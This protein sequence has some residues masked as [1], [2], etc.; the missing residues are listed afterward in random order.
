MLKL[1]IC[2]NCLYRH[3]NFDDIYKNA[4]LNKIKNLYQK[5][6]IPTALYGCELW[7]NITKSERDI[8]SRLQHNVAKR[9]QGFAKRTRSDMCESMLGLPHLT[10][11]IDKRKLMFLRKFLSLPYEAQCHKIFIHRYLQYL[12]PRNAALVQKGFI[13]DI[14]MLLC[15]YNLQY[16]LNDYFND[17]YHCLVN[18][19]EKRV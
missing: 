9:I 10:F 6:V 17:A 2:L 12:E 19:Y 16:I 4:L 5:I 18:I 1:T 8:I 11:E 3:T 7:N 14:C 13:P 15:Q